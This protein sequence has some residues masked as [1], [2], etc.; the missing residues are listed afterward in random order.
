MTVTNDD[1]SKWNMAEHDFS[2]GNDRAENAV[3]TIQLEL[4]VFLPDEY[5]EFLFVTH[6]ESIR[7]LRESRHCLSK[8]DSGTR[9]IRIIA[10]SASDEVVEMTKLSQESIYEHRSLLPNGLIVIG[11]NYDGDS[12]SCIVYDVR[13][14]SPTY[15]HVFNWRYYVDNLVVGDGLGLLA[16]SLKAFLH[17]PTAANE[18]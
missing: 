9:I 4:N 17:T 16:L 5:R 1:F 18:L 12:D 10:L 8:H 11:S 7:P 6:D 13:P 3:K 15:L 14:G 2:D